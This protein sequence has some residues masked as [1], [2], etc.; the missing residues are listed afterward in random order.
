MTTLQFKGNITIDDIFKDYKEEIY[1]SVL[2]SIKENYLNNEINEI[3]VVKIN[4]QSKEYSIN[5]T[6]DKFVLTLNKCIE[7]FVELELY[8]LCQE[9]LN[10]IKEIEA[11]K[12]TI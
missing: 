6:R 2:K 8:E 9:C 11:E 4:T 1:R 7:F 5:L 12:I 3:I 10:I